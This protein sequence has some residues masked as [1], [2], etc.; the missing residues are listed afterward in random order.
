MRRLRVRHAHQ[1]VVV[2]AEAHR[3]VRLRVVARRPRHHKRPARHTA[4]R[5]CRRRPQHVVDGGDHEASR[6]SRGG[7]RAR[8]RNRVRVQVDLEHAEPSG[9]GRQRKLGLGEVGSR[10]DA[11]QLLV[12][13]VGP[14]L[15]HLQLVAKLVDPFGSQ[16][17]QQVLQPLGSL[18]VVASHPASRARLVTDAYLRGVEVHR[19]CCAR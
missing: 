11:Q 2:E 13:D 12:G 17:L 8:A 19:Y 18:R 7:P 16:R 1:H 6:A 4:R 5:R 10:V 3:P 15:V 14:R 9:R